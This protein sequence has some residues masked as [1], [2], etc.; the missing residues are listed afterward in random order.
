M[1]R[2]KDLKLTDFI[3]CCVD[4]DLHS[5]VI[6][7]QA[8][9]E[10]LGN[11]WLH[12]LSQYYE[13][14]QDARANQ[15]RELLGQLEALKIRAAVI[16]MLVEAYKCFPTQMIIERLRELGYFDLQFT[17]E[18]MDNDLMCIRNNEINYQIEHDNIKEELEQLSKGANDKATAGHKIFYDY[19]MSYNEAYKTTYTVDGLNAFE[20]ALIC[21][22]LDEYIEHLNTQNRQTN[23]R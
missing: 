6:S 15:H 12:L 17:P 7:G 14:R 5:I 3:A 2:L 4:N 11:A 20:Y 23:A 9:E 10:Q 22:R 8:D 21:H 1:S 13:A 19:V 16:E 18:T